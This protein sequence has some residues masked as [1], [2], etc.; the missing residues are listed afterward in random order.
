MR[1]FTAFLVVLIILASV[2]VFASCS[3][4][5]PKSVTENF[6]DL[7]KDGEFV[8]K[9]G[10]QGDSA[11][12]EF[13][14][15]ITF[16]TL[17]LKEKTKSITSFRVYADDEQEPFYGN[18][19]IESYRYCSFE[20]VTA[21]S[22]RIQVLSSDGK[23]TMADVEA[24]NVSDTVGDQGFE[25]MSYI[26]TET[27]LTMT[28]GQKNIAKYVT[29]FNLY[30]N[31]YLEASGALRFT[32]YTIDG[33]AVDGKTALKNAVQALKSINPSATVVATVFG[34][35]D[36][37]DGLSVI[38]RHSAA[39]GD[40]ADTLIANINSVISE[41]GLDGIS[42]DYEYPKKMKDFDI[43]A[44]FLKKL[45]NSMEQ[46]KMLTTALATWNISLTFLSKKDL[47]P[48]DRIEIMSY[49]LFDERGNHAE[50]Y[51]T[52]YEIYADLLKRGVPL[53]KI[54]L[55]LPFYSRPV[56]GDSFWG[57]YSDVA[58]K[59]S[60]FENTFVEA[61]TDLDG[62]AHPETANYYNGRQMIYDK[63]CFAIDS[64]MRG[65]MIWHFGTDST[66]P[67]LSLIMQI[68]KAVMSRATK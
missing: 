26:S 45:K 10:S 13:G 24:Y 15:E 41:C 38:Q 40:N 6:D 17:V 65:V 63:T 56:N 33:V 29:D 48:V 43:Y 44:K 55:G 25:V 42:F 7:A 50:F 62:N 12:Y 67:E 8:V 27:T 64:G 39:M 1:K 30:G 23:W 66:D 3:D 37:G 54:H 18:D 46:G 22:V 53:E 51:N 35:K 60:P 52:C 36:F 11:V 28:E 21:K 49:D 47:E 5:T 19:F 57:N 58:S 68:N 59:L 16:N 34:N 32:E 31:I 61:Y 20:S 9:D 4:A 2:F 14:K